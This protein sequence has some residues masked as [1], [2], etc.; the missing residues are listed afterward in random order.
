MLETPPQ[1]IRSILE[2]RHTW[3]YPCWRHH[4][5]WYDPCWRHSHMI[6]PMLKTPPHMIWLNVF[7]SFLTGRDVYISHSYHFGIQV[8]WHHYEVV[9]KIH[10]RA[11]ERYCVVLVDAHLAFDTKISSIPFLGSLQWFQK[12]VFYMY[13]SCLHV[14][15]WPKQIQRI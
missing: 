4:H 5:T 6:L 1:L 10:N 7:S 9:S 14:T 3:S 15:L 2:I 8:P 12:M 11:P 13:I